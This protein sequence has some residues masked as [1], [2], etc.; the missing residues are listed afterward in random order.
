MSL[1]LVLTAYLIG[2]ALA[3]TS[4]CQGRS[5]RNI[6]KA[7][8]D[9]NNFPIGVAVNP[10]TNMIYITNAASNTVSVINGENDKIEHTIPVGTLPYDVDVDPATNKIYV[11]NKFS[12]SLSVIDGDTNAII[13]TINNVTSPVGID[14]DSDNSWIYV[15]NID[16]NTVSKIDAINN[17]V[18][19][20]AKVG[21]DPYTIDIKAGRDPKIYVTNLG[22]DSVSVLNATTFE[23]LK[24]ITVG[25]SPVGLAANRYTNTVYVSNRAEDTVSIIDAV[26]NTVVNNLKVGC[27]PDGIDINFRTNKV[28]VTNT[29]SNTVSVIDGRT[30]NIIKEIAVNNNIVNNNIDPELNPQHLPPSLKFPNV[31]TFIDNNDATNKTYVTNTGSSTVSVIDSNANSLLVGLT[32][33]NNPPNQ[34][35]I[36]YTNTKNKSDNY[37]SSSSEYIRVTYGKEFECIAYPKVGYSFDFWSGNLLHNA[38]ET[39]ERLDPISSVISYFKELF[40]PQPSSA[41]TFNATEYGPEL[42]ANYKTGQSYIPVLLIPIIF[43]IFIPFMIKGLKWINKKLYIRLFEQAYI[44]QHDKLIEDAYRASMISIKEAKERLSLLR[45]DLIKDLH[46]GDCDDNEYRAL[47]RKITKYREELSNGNTA[48]KIQLNWKSSHSWKN[49]FKI[50]RQR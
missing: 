44:H 18:V 42:T 19:K 23:T 16:N 2:T 34:G 35:Y 11:A 7:G 26:S 14:I 32:I 49:I 15:T 9:V 40:S 21:E 36:E 22:S 46:N 28:Y 5:P 25:K 10:I 31:A 39:K 45:N 47:E 17:T 33:K 48:A 1:L 30:N 4:D 27:Q 8:I 13:K 38:T 6:I 43:T 20:Y 3:Y 37:A 29:G 12:D 24:N 41:Q 50:N